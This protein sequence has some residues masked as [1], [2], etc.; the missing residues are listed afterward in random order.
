MRRQSRRMA[1]E[2]RRTSTKH[3]P[4]DERL[5]RITSA[6]FVLA[7][8]ILLCHR[9]V[10]TGFSRQRGI[11]FKRLNIPALRVS[12]RTPRCSAGRSRRSRA[13]RRARRLRARV[14]SPTST[15]RRTSRPSRP[16]G[17]TS[18]RNPI[19]SSTRVS[20]LLLRGEVRN[21]PGWTS[22]WRLGAPGKRR[23][24]IDMCLG[25]LA[26]VAAGPRPVDARVR[27]VFRAPR[28]FFGPASRRS[29]DHRSGFFHPR[30]EASV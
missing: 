19:G 27:A 23:E 4:D 15:P 28:A 2:S 16:A 9:L 26:R 14:A 30:S 20:P 17:W 7:H 25:T 12:P 6:A 5:S 21:V 24:R 11:P 3:L 22:P 13:S 1:R 8:I 10:A 18:A 29:R